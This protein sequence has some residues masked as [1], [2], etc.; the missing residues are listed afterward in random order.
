LPHYIVNE[1]S[2]VLEISPKLKEHK[3]EKL[4]PKSYF[5]SLN[6]HTVFDFWLIGCGLV[7]FALQESVNK[8]L[9]GMHSTT[10]MFRNSK[11]LQVCFL[12]YLMSFSDRSCLGCGFDD[13]AKFS[14]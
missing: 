13:R 14:S 3:I 9:E 2:P 1:E 7:V 11:R 4:L 10:T 8:G 12:L 6:V 5:N